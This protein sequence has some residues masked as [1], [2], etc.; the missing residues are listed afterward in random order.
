MEVL[1][2][3]LV[4]QFHPER[5]ILFGSQAAGRAGAE[6]DVDLLLVMEHPG[7]SV[8]QAVAIRRFLD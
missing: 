5:V 7:R 4:A 6:S 3:R 1:A 2:Q 8:E